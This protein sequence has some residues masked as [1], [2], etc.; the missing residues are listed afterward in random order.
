MVVSLE[1]Q[2]ALSAAP[3]INCETAHLINQLRSPVHVCSGVKFESKACKTFVLRRMFTRADLEAVSQTR[4]LNWEKSRSQRSCLRKA[5]A[6]SSVVITGMVV[7][8][9]AIAARLSHMHV[10]GAD[11]ADALTIVFGTF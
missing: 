2:L 11:R 5:S 6:S 3:P 1:K 10:A 7:G 8:L 9:G 4:A